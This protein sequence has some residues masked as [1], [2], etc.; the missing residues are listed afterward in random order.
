MRRFLTYTSLLITAIWAMACS[1]STEQKDNTP[2][3]PKPL[4]TIQTDNGAVPVYDFKTFEPI[5]RQSDD[6]VYVVNFWATWCKP[7]VEELPHFDELQKHYSNKAVKVILVSLDFKEQA[8]K[9]LA[10][11]ISKRNVTSEVMLMD[12]ADANT[13][14]NAINKEW[15]GAIPAT[16]IYKGDKSDFYEQQFDYNE[17]EDAVKKF[18]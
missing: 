10:S 9:K 8:E 18:L 15:S 13:W 6:T 12:D 11:F 2:E 5:L 1:S 3:R 4:S 14:I 16:Y 17:L 7:C